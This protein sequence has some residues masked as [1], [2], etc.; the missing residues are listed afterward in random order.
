MNKNEKDLMD[1]LND[2]DDISVEEIAEKYPALNENTK[3]RILKKC[4][5]KGGFSAEIDNNGKEEI[6]ISG[7]ERYNRN[8]WY[9]FVA[10]AAA[11]VLAVGGITSVFMLNRNIV[12]ND[13]SETGKTSAVRIYDSSSNSESEQTAVT[14]ADSDY[15][16]SSDKTKS[17]EDSVTTNN[18]PISLSGTHWFM[19]EDTGPIVK[20]IDF[21]NDSD[22][23]NYI[24]SPYDVTTTESTKIP[25][26]YVQ[27]GYDIDIDFSIDAFGSAMAKLSIDNWHATLAIEWLDGHTEYFHNQDITTTSSDNGNENETPQTPPTT[28][29][30]PVSDPDNSASQTQKIYLD[31]VYY[32]GIAGV[33]GYM[34]FEFWPD[35]RLTKYAFDDFGDVIYDTMVTLNYEIV[36]NQFSFGDLNSELNKK[37]GTILNP[38]DTSSFSVQFSDGL[39]NFSTERPEFRKPSHAAAKPDTVNGTIWSWY[40]G[41]DENYN[42][43]EIRKIVFKEDGV[44]GTTYITLFP[45]DETKTELIKI[46]FTYEQNGDEITFNM[47]SS[48]YNILKATL[49]VADAGEKLSLDV[50]Y[51]NGDR[52]FFA[53]SGSLNNYN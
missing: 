45:Y 50:E 32:V 42:Y 35:G 4:M 9:K 30:S 44:N 25:F 22:S 33:H 7:T 51:Q 23:G 43:T 20:E 47:E 2:L 21:N 3:K 18:K 10:S 15:N 41:W 31:K 26:T 28:K 27:N 12:G 39:Y 34:G 40:T 8:P 38:N 52:N 48:T 5:E 14:T 17:E 37:I 13:S 16:Y 53:L 11:L 24:I 6:I 19:Y 46:P 1:Q 49:C 36:E 29:E